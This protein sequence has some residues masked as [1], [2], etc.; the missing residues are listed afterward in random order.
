VFSL[1]QPSPAIFREAV[2]GVSGHK[3]VTMAPQNNRDTKSGF[4]YAG[5]AYLIW[6][7]LPLKVKLLSHIPAWEIVALRILCSHHTEIAGGHRGR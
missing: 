2:Q 5:S 6:S 7:V 3:P 4:L 1:T